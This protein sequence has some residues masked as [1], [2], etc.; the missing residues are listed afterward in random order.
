MAKKRT[1][2]GE[3]A[4]VSE[5]NTNGK[6]YWWKVRGWENGKM[7]LW[8]KQA[9]PYA[10]RAFRV[11]NGGQSKKHQAF[12]LLL[13]F[14]LNIHMVVCEFVICQSKSLPRSLGR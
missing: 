9:G 12:A 14:I 11:P 3:R 10:F 4:R 5:T 2:P 7:G 8:V 6:L 1:H 13:C